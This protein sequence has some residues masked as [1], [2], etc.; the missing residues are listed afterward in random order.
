MARTAN[1]NNAGN[2]APAQK[3]LQWN[4]GKYLRLSKEDIK[5]GEDDSNSV[6]NQKSI[7]MQYARQNRFPNPTFFIDDGYSGV[8]FERPGFQKM[9]DEV[10]VGNVLCVIVKDG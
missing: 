2:N 10:E 3:T 9:L 6:I 4:L 8:S 5:K 7:L 1:R